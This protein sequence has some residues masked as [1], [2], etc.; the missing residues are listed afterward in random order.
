MEDTKLKIGSYEFDSRLIIGTGKY[1][2]F[3]LMADALEAS[4]AEMITVAMGRVDLSNP[5]QKNLLDHI[6]RVGVELC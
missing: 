2:S 4:G 3:E 1:A 6:D 5:N